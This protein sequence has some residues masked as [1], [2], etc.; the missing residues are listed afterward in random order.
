[1][2]LSLVRLEFPEGANLIAGQSHFIK[3]VEDLYEIL[4]SSMPGI[5]FGIAFSEASGECL[6]RSDGNAPE[7][8]E[9]AVKNALAV[10]AGH[11]F[12]I[13]LRKAYPINVLNAVKACQEVCSIY[14]ATANPVQAIVALDGD[15]A[16]IL[17]VIDGSSPKGVE[18][19]EHQ[20]KRKQL[21]QAIG[22][23]R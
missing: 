3:T 11:T 1:M 12:Y 14:C 15:G 9:A 10:A 23:K 17:G 22:Y 6:V 20:E 8:I 13:V 5:E 7:L 21:L 4:I 2:E 19:P 18:G 16:G